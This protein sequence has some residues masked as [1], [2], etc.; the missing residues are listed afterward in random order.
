MNFTYY[1]IIILIVRR[2]ENDGNSLAPHSWHCCCYYYIM[3][4]C[5]VWECKS[6]ELFPHTL[7]TH[8]LCVM[9]STVNL[10]VMSLHSAQ[11]FNL[12][13]QMQLILNY[14]I[15]LAHKKKS[16]IAPN[17]YSAVTH[18]MSPTDYYS[19]THSPIPLY[20]MLIAVS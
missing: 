20:A 1:L 6:V 19:L 16:N 3:M 10:T 17:M 15:I 7:Y 4:I 9:S 18:V 11:L 14:I 8:P 2:I 13:P 12:L 5:I